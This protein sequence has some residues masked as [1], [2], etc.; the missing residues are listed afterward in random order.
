MTKVIMLVDDSV[1]VRKIVSATLGA[2]GY[3]VIQGVDGQDALTQLEGGVAVDL[4]ITDI[5]MPNMDGITF[6]GE[7]RKLV[8]CKYTPVIMLTTEVDPDM[9]AKGK[10]VGA[11]AWMVKPFQPAQML[12][13]VQKF[14]TP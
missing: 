4:I 1:S 7:A 6:I 8:Q 13:A 14:I 12:A 3:K 2:M 9:K 11:R 5:N 10:A